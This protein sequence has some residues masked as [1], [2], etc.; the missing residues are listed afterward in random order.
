MEA[1]PALCGPAFFCA[2][3][4]PFRC[5]VVSSRL[6]RLYASFALMLG[7]RGLFG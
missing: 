3:R 6:L 5:F 1:A 4:L 7:L 2:L